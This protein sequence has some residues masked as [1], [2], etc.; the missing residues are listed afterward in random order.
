MPDIPFGPFINSYIRNQFQAKLL[1][2][3]LMPTDRPFVLFWA[4]AEKEIHG[5]GHQVA[6]FAGS[7]LRCPT[8][9]SPFLYLCLGLP[10]TYCRNTNGYPLRG[11]ADYL[12]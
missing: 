8:G 12:L 5:T 11:I 2:T 7:P 6:L 9:T 1:P 4:F 10:T 3:L